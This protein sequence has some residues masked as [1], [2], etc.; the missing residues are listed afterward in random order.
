MKERLAL[1]AAIV[2]AAIMGAI[3]FMPSIAQLERML[4]F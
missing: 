4:G 3:P 1:V 2:L